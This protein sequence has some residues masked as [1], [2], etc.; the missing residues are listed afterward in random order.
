[1][2]PPHGTPANP[3]HATCTDCQTVK[4]SGKLDEGG[5]RWRCDQC[6]SRNAIAIG[7]NAS[8]KL[9]LSS[10]E[11]LL[12]KG[13]RA[14]FYLM[15]ELATAVPFAGYVAYCATLQNIS[16]RWLIVNGL[17]A[18]GWLGM[19]GNAIVLHRRIRNVLKQ[20]ELPE[21]SVVLRKALREDTS[22]SK[23]TTAP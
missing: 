15:F 23:A 4:S 20:L 17:L 12:K 14:R 11:A 1:M 8:G 13:K 10:R 5:D 2:N 7:D 16:S 22:A 9:E 19:A 3:A 21:A 18:L 6:K